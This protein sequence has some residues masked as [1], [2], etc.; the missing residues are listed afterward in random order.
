MFAYPK[1]VTDPGKWIK[2]PGQHDKT[3]S[4]H[5]ISVEEGQ[6]KLGLWHF[7]KQT[8]SAKSRKTLELLVFQNPESLE[9]HDDAFITVYAIPKSSKKVDLKVKITNSYKT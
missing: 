3:S 9:K 1:M 2:A 7:C 4:V 6:I 5:V 8:A